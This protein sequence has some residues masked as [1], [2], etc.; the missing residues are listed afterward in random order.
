M[1]GVS[2]KLQNNI[3]SGFGIK[4][5][6]IEYEKRKDWIN[7]SETIIANNQEIGSIS[8]HHESDGYIMNLNI[9]GQN[10]T[11][12]Q[13]Y[14]DDNISQ[15]IDTI[16]NVWDAFK[17][18]SLDSIKEMV[19]PKIYGASGEEIC[20]MNYGR[21]GS[22]E[23][24]Q[25]SFNGMTLYMYHVLKVG[26]S[27]NY[28]IYNDQNQLVGI[29]KRKWKIR[30]NPQTYFYAVNDQYMP[31][32]VL[33]YV[34]RELNKTYLGE[35]Q[36]QFENVNPT[37]ETK[38]R[39]SEDFIKSIEAAAGPQNL[40]ENMPLYQEKMN[41]SKRHNKSHVLKVIGTIVLIICLIAIFCFAMFGNK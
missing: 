6:N 32:L 34:A 30:Y 5:N 2:I 15:K 39:Y 21:Q 28:C 33:L 13:W 12:K 35:E 16:K 24:Y 10:Y 22:S 3:Q 36:D 40:P 27:Y 8:G 9:L 26:N 18:K 31:Y 23:Y 14:R 41:Q 19:Y 38:Q 7:Y 25:F 1:L 20:V 11:L 37:A 17:N 4:V 29:I